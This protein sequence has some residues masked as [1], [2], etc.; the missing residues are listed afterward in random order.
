MV[1]E[2]TTKAG[3]LTYT[4]IERVTVERPR[5]IAFE[6]LE[7]PLEYARDE[8]LLHEVREGT[9]LTHRGEFIWRRTPLVGWLGGRFFTKPL[10]ERAMERHMGMIKETCEARAERSR[11]FR[12][13]A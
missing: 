7:G 4:T 8:F 10:F 5:R 3:P 1:V 2:F 6:H 9:E 13:K 12:R 11:V